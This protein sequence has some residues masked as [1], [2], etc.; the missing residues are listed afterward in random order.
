MENI[1]KKSRANA[2]SSYLMIGIAWAF[3]LNK[4]NPYISNSF[5][6]SHT[7]TALLL[8]FG[9][10]MNYIVFIHLRPL[11]FF[12]IFIGYSLN[13]IVAIALFFILLYFLWL[14]MVRAH[15]GKYLST[16]EIISISWDKKLIDVNGDL[17]INQRDKT[18]LLL[19]HIPFIGAYL[20]GKYAN[21]KA[22]QSIGVINL[23]ITS[24][25]LLA[26]IDG[27]SNI[28]N[29]L[30]LIYTIYIVFNG[31]SLFA[32]DKLIQI[33]TQ[34]FPTPSS[35][36]ILL[37]TLIQYLS[38]YFTNKKFSDFSVLQSNITGQE[39][40]HKKQLEKDLQSLPKTQKISRYKIYLQSASIIIL[41]GMTLFFSDITS[42][43]F[44]VLLL[45][46]IYTLWYIPY[47]LSYKTPFIHDIYTGIAYTT[48]KIKN[49]FIRTKEL[50]NKEE[51][52]S[53]KISE[54]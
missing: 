3:L 53:L 37:L 10:I 41:L 5:V 25:I 24:L 42:R 12:D 6:K 27:H 38:N 15:S 33:N 11:P 2:L 48:Q 19:S 45:I 31:V 23:Y 26:Y 35:L 51:K 9:L 28:V 30:L 14:G 21:Y 43:Y 20:Y 34:K 40:E 8:H 7:K 13:E 52:I 47:S 16:K 36:R 22:I 1:H 49:I 18:T 32:Q 4:E 46:T 39:A 44:S 17:K 29:I 50:H 54:K